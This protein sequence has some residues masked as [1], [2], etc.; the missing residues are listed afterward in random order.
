[1]QQSAEP[2]V[3]LDL[4]IDAADMHV[5]F[6]QPITQALV[7][8]PMPFWE[9]DSIGNRAGDVNQGGESPL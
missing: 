6:Y 3:T 8:D 5:R 9:I 7:V 4:A 2:F 1:M